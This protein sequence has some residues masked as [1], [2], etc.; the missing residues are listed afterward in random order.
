M[1]ERRTHVVAEPGAK[2]TLCGIKASERE[3]LPIVAAQHVGAHIRGHGMTVCDACAQRLE[4]GAIRL[5]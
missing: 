4:G 1:T 5:L 2:R 3:A